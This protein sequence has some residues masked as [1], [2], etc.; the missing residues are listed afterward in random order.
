MTTVSM[1]FDEISR[2]GHDA[3]RANGYPP[4]LAEAAGEMTVWLE[5]HRFPGVSVLAAVLEAGGRFDPGRR[6]PETLES[7]ELRFD[8]PIQAGFHL[9]ENFD[10]IRFP[11][12]INGPRFGTLLLVPFLALAAH[13]RSDGIR[14]SFLGLDGETAGAHIAYANGRSAF[15]GEPVAAGFSTR[16]GVEFPLRPAEP[17]VT[18]REDPVDIPAEFRDALARY[19]KA[20]TG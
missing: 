8:E 15:S 2:L 1:S 3:A 16:L 17:L 20:A 14:F 13:Q 9:Y 11:A 5:R 10:R 18:P 12:R 7:G 19:A 6:V 4:E